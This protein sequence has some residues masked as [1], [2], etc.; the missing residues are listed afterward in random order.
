[1]CRR[2]LSLP[3]WGSAAEVGANAVIAMRYDANDIA[4]GD[5][6][7]SGLWD[8]GGHRIGVSAW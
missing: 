8:R 1:M 4:A 7:G 2:W 3:T 5:Y 6:G